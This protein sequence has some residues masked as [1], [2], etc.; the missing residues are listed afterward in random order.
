MSPDSQK[1]NL[2]MYNNIKYPWLKNHPHSESF[3]EYNDIIL[4]NSNVIPPITVIGKKDQG[5]K[6]TE[7]KNNL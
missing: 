6:N 5:K 1:I 4:L 3:F 2:Y 7:K